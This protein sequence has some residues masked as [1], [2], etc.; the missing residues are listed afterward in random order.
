[1]YGSASPWANRRRA[2]RG[3]VVIHPILACQP[4]RLPSMPAGLG[5][6]ND[7]QIRSY[8]C[9]LPD[10]F[11]SVRDLGFVAARRSSVRRTGRSFVCVAPSMA[12]GCTSSPASS[13][14][15]SSSPAG[16]LRC[17]LALS[18]SGPSPVPDCSRT[19]RQ[20]GSVQ[21]RR[22]R[23]R[24]DARGAL[25]RFWLTRKPLRGVRGGQRLFHR[26]NDY[27]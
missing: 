19:A 22:C 18:C 24:S 26:H 1:L 4:P 8:P 23:S 3:R 5:R 15:C 16:R 7:H 11:R 12:P 14:W 27:R 17:G 25:D 13:P 9:A 2:S 20:T 6:R 10:S 21:G